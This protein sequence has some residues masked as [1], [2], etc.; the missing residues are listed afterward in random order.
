MVL[1]GAEHWNGVYLQK[2]DDETSWFQAFPETSL[3]LLSHARLAAGAQ[4]IDVGAGRSRLV[5]GLIDRGMEH[6]TL[7][8]LSGQAL[9]STRERLG[10]R[11]H[12][13]AF[14][15]GDVTAFTPSRA[16]DA[17]HDR[18]VF[19][20]LVSPEDRARYVAVLEKALRPGG[21]VVLG[22]FALDGPAKCS[23]LPVAR[24]DARGL[25]EALGLG[26]ALEE[27]TRD[28]HV[29]PSGKLQPFTFARFVKVPRTPPAA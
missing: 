6:V 9:A 11:G 16:Y 20:F 21:H 24:Y 4:V 27:S 22:T 18:A 1:S 2:R 28:L 26:F 3:Q 12:S 8:D 19:H 10:E 15:A 17:W 13:V 14:I 5:E 25:A 23:G 29:T 7:L